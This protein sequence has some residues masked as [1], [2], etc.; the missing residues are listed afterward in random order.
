[1]AA[2]FVQPATAD[3][4]VKTYLDSDGNIAEAWTSTERRKTITINGFKL[5]GTYDE[6][7]SIINAIFGD[8][9]YEPNKTQKVTTFIVESDAV[10]IEFTAE[11]FL[12][13]L[14]GT[15][16]PTSSDFFLDMISILDG[17]YTTRGTMF[18]AADFI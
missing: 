17:T 11:D 7:I 16:V 13:I 1:M 5:E 3:L 9:I 8:K 14:N 6:A 15:Y 2:E 18:T 12:P 4:K 10:E